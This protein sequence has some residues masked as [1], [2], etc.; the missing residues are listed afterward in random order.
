MNTSL[1]ICR[2]LVSI[3]C[4]FDELRGKTFLDNDFDS[5][6]YEKTGPASEDEPDD[7][8]MEAA[9]VDVKQ[10]ARDPLED[11]EG[12]EEEG[13]EE[14]EEWG[15]RKLTERTGPKKPLTEAR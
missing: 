2:G 15:P 14:E 5:E 1:L 10:E 7:S 12:A 11:Q 9:E 4:I 13:E 8:Y 6:G 3:H